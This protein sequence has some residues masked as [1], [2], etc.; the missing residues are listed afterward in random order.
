MRTWRGNH[1][2]AEQQSEPE[3]LAA[4]ARTTA[5]RTA[6]ARAAAARAAPE[7]GPEPPPEDPG[8]GS[9][10][11]SQQGQGQPEP[12]TP[13]APRE[14]PPSEG[15]PFGEDTRWPTRRS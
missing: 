10:S 8:P 15:I 4:A 2:P 14:C 9:R 6:A 5:A 13:V 3:P 12:L 7:P 11:Q 1:E